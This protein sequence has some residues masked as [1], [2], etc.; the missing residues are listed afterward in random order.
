MVWFVQQCQRKL[1]SNPLQYPGRILKSQLSAFSSFFFFLEMYSC[2]VWQMQ[3]NI[4]FYF[5]PSPACSEFHNSVQ[6][7]N[8]VFHRVLDPDCDWLDIQYNDSKILV[9]APQRLPLK[10]IVFYHCSILHHILKE[11]PGVKAALG[12]LLDG[13]KCKLSPGTK[14]T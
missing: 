12:L 8:I 1:H 4:T 6:S 5:S 7:S 3:W 10:F 11:P 9:T 2:E 13:T 14:M